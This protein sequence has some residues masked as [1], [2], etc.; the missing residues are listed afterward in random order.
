RRVPPHPGIPFKLLEILDIENTPCVQNLISCGSLGSLGAGLGHFLLTSGI[1]R[2][3]NVAGVGGF[4][5]VILGYW[6]HCRYNYAKTRIQERI[7]IEGIKNRILYENT[8]L[9]PERKQIDSSSSSN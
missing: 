4:I 2:S 3:G 1:R 9:Y 8:H 7:A 5:L 6:S